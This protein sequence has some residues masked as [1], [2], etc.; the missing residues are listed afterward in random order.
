MD[1]E[2]H[3]V[4]DGGFQQVDV[5]GILAGRN[6]KYRVAVGLIEFEFDVAEEDKTRIDYMAK[7]RRLVKVTGNIRYA[8]N[9][10][11]YTDDVTI[12]LI[13]ANIQ[14]LGWMNEQVVAAETALREALGGRAHPDDTLDELAISAKQTIER[15]YED[16]Q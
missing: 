11:P 13:N 9:N 16:N 15:I 4:L 8:T 2:Y 3:V 7:D 5:I 1:K 12:H 14:Q 6:G 10:Y